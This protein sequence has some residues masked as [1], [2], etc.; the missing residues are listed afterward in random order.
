MNTQPTSTPTPSNAE[1]A[2]VVL[3][4]HPAPAAATK[5]PTVTKKPPTKKID[6]AKKSARTPRKIDP[7]IAAIHAK[8][9]EE[10]AQYRKTTASGRILKTI[11]KKRLAQLT[12]EDRQRLLDELAKTCTPPLFTKP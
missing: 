4:T 1:P 5:K 11:I 2:K 8:A 12:L 7:G 9:K 3:P 6:P 10:V